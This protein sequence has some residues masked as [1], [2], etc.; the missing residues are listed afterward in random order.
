M[1]GSYLNGVV[2]KAARKYLGDNIMYILK[3]HWSK[4]GAEESEVANLRLL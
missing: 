4:L 3:C 1:R 2:V